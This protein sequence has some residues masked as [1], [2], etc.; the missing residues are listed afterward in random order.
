MTKPGTAGIIRT[1]CCS[2]AKLGVSRAAGL[3]KHKSRMPAFEG[4]LDHGDVIAAPSYIKS[5]WPSDV[6][7]RHDELNRSHQQVAR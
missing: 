3:K 1:G 7:R 2:I 5:R 6:R 4:V